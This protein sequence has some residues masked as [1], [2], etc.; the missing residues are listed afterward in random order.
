MHH[1]SSCR[2]DKHTI[3]TGKGKGKTTLKQAS[4][5]VL[6]H[7]SSDHDSVKN[8][9]I[10]T[11]QVVSSFASHFLRPHWQAHD[12]WLCKFKYARTHPP[13][14]PPTTAPLMLF[15]C[16]QWFWSCLPFSTATCL[17]SV[18]YTTLFFWHPAIQTQESWLSCF[19]LLWTPH[20]EFTPTRP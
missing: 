20:F 18:S 12:T 14:P 1:S 15:E 13:P 5:F 9:Y 11:K 2:T 6:H 19:L 4:L 8:I 10:A 16:F 7:A 3:R 17:H